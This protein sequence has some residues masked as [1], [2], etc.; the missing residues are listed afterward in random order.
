MIRQRLRIGC[1]AVLCVSQAACADGTEPRTIEVSVQASSLATSVHFDEEGPFVVCDLLLKATAVGSKQMTATWEDG[2]IEILGGPTRIISA[3]Y[4]PLTGEELGEIWSKQ[5]ITADEDVQTELRLGHWE[6]FSGR[7]SFRYLPEGATTKETARFNFQCEADGF[8]R[9]EVWLRFPELVGVDETIDTGQSLSV[10]YHA[11][12]DLGVVQTEVQVSNG[13]FTVATKFSELGYSSGQPS[14]SSY[15]TVQV[16]ITPEHPLGSR[17]RVRVITTA[18]SGAQ[19][20]SE[21]MDGPIVVDRSPPAFF[22]RCLGGGIPGD[23][24]SSPGEFTYTAGDT[25]HLRVIGADNHE[26]RYFVWRVGDIVADSILVDRRP[27]IVHEVR[28]PVQSNWSDARS[29]TIYFRDAVGNFG[30]AVE[31][32]IRMVPQVQARAETLLLPGVFTGVSDSEGRNLYL[33][34]GS[35]AIARLS[36]ETMSEVWRLQLSGTP[37]GIDLAPGEA[38]LAVPLQDAKAVAFLD[39]A[40]RLTRTVAL[41]DDFSPQAAVYT[42][43]GSLVVTGSAAVMKRVSAGGEIVSPPVLQHSYVAPLRPIRSPDYS[44]V[45][46]RDSFNCVFVLIRV[47]EPMREC[48]SLNGFVPMFSADGETLVNGSSLLDRELRLI[49]Q[50]AIPGVGPRVTAISRDGRKVYWTHRKGLLVIDSAS[51]RLEGVLAHAVPA[52]A[53]LQAGDDRLILLSY[54]LIGNQIHTR[55]GV[56]ELE[57]VE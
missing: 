30:E 8:D 50:I 38:S 51:G 27:G 24:I 19:A 31:Y 20:I 3:G 55:I 2:Q 21:W 26:L 34:S 57:Q 56:V 43:D 23:C 10:R 14:H 5:A 52:D 32:P 48:R 45:F 53:T 33:S 28:I 16:P 1:I 54:P 25:F 7:G 42:A 4:I 12:G 47:E 35:G 9:G 13:S 29:L 36:L 6:P 22:S 11:G 15:R 44:R 18:T 37:K 40:G 46:V 39:V 17:L 49:R 41:G